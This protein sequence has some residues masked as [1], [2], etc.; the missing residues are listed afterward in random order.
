MLGLKIVDV[1]AGAVVP[2]V[3]PVVLVPVE[4][5]LAPVVH[6]ETEAVPRAAVIA[7]AISVALGGA[8]GVGNPMV[9]NM[10]QL[11]TPTGA[12]GLTCRWER[13]T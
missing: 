13:P 11:C 1:I 10:S 8:D 5:E 7:E 4:D 2:G 9:S 12:V 3:L 6:A